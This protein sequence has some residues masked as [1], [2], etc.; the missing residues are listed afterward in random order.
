[1]TRF[2]WNI[3]GQSGFGKSFFIKN[4]IIPRLNRFIV[5]DTIGEYDGENIVYNIDDVVKLYKQYFSNEQI[6]IIYRPNDPDEIL[7]VA[8]IVNTN[9]YITAIFEEIHIYE[10]KSK[11]PIYTIFTTGRHRH[12]NV[13]GAAQSPSRVSR[14]MRNQAT[15][16]QSFH[17]HGQMDIKALYEFSDK[18]NDL[19]N[20]EFKEFF[21]L[22]GENFFR[23]LM[24]QSPN[25]FSKYPDGAYKLNI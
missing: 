24:E 22:H 20:L 6:K 1:M 23:T 16:V 4:F 12:I 19:V 7:D 10:P 14:D 11:S 2:V 25:T 15:V 17:Q 5:F 8:D 3:F 9:G 13:V 21:I 18:A